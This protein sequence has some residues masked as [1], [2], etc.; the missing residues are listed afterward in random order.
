MPRARDKAT[1]CGKWSPAPN[2]LQ[3]VSSAC[4]GEKKAIPATRTEQITADFKNITAPR[5]SKPKAPAI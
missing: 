5:C 3:F 4:T 1:T 2:A